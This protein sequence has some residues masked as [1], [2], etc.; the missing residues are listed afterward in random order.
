MQCPHCLEHFHASWKY[1]GIRKDREQLWRVG[2]T[3]CAAC[4]RVIIMLGEVY[5]AADAAGRSVY[6]GRASTFTLVYPKGIS[7]SPIPSE[8]PPEFAAE[9]FEGQFVQSP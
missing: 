7:R 8:V 1:I 3:V 5:E 6:L 4:G 2:E 9:Y